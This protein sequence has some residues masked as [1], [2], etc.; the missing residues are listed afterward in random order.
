M[1][2]SSKHI[3]LFLFALTVVFFPFAT[4]AA[5][6]FVC[7]NGLLATIEYIRKSGA[8]GQNIVDSPY[9]LFKLAGCILEQATNYIIMLGG[10]VAVIMIMVSGLRYMS[11]AG[12]PT[13]QQ[14]AVKSLNASVVGLAILLCFWSVFNFMLKLLQVPESNTAVATTA[15]SNL[16]KILNTGIGVFIWVAGV[17]SVLFIILGGVQYITAGA[18]KDG[19]TKAKNTLIYALI[20]TVVVVLALV[21]RNY[22]LDKIT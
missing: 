4:S 16:S 14:N 21:I 11:S 1:K 22:V 18:S 3:L 5:G 8:G 15:S 2:I 7:Q 10:V 12:N 19:A 13:N 6:D 17:L 20:G 9:A